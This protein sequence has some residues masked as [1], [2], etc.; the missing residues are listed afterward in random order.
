MSGQHF[1]A[2][3]RVRGKGGIRFNR[4]SRDQ[5]IE[6]TTEDG[7]CM[8]IRMI[9]GPKFKTGNH[10][11]LATNLL[12][13]KKYTRGELLALYK[14][15]QA[16]EEVFLHLKNTL[17]VKN[18]RSKKVN[19]VLQEVYAALTM[20]S[21]VA[22]IQYLFERN[23]KYKRISFKAI[24]WRLETAIEVLLEP[25]SRYWINRLFG[26][27]NN[28]GHTQQPGRSYPRWSVQPENKWIK[29]KRQKVYLAKKRGSNA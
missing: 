22:G 11:Y 14:K 28:F 9:R 13:P 16:V 5:I 2:R 10:L 3:I 29:E 6:F 21:I 8:R 15:R 7:E 18:I 27:L 24:A 12:D 17:H 20:T 23:L 19:G 25:K 26:G 1:L 4:D